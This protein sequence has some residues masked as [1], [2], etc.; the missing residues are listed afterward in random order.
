MT[1]ASEVIV[2]LKCAMTE[3]AYPGNLGFQELVKFYQQANSI[4]IEAM[5]TVIK[6]SD[7]SGFKNLINKVL[8]VKLQ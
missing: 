6:N 7:W 5:E 2:S 1:K 4:Q 8:R 3:A